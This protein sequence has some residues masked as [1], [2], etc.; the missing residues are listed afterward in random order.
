MHFAGP[1]FDAIY[2][3]PR[4]LLRPPAKTQTANAAGERHAV[5]KFSIY[6]SA[7]TARRAQNAKHSIAASSNRLKPLN[8]FMALDIVACRLI[9][10]RGEKLI[11]R[12]FPVRAQRDGANATN[13]QY[14]AISDSLRSPLD[15]CRPW[16]ARCTRKTSIFI[17]IKFTS[18]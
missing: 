13:V 18:T 2:R 6:G 4:T 8:R 15:D 1:K 14:C 16:S 11:C 5:T 3:R 9:A 7:G 12:P 10:R 17:H